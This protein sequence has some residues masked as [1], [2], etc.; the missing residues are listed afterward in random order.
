MGAHMPPHG[1]TEHHAV[2]LQE[3]AACFKSALDALRLDTGC[4]CQR[5]PNGR[6]R[7]TVGC[8]SARMLIAKA[9]GR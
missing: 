7:H 4:W 2:S 9:E 3:R 6:G 8:K 5:P 1:Q